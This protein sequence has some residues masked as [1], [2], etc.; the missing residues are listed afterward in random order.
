MT[1][2]ARNCVL[3]NAERAE[4]KKQLPQ[5]SKEERERWR[6]GRRGSEGRRRRRREKEIEIK[7]MELGLFSSY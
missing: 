5:E 4:Y 2:F 1:G 6:E 3:Y 7:T